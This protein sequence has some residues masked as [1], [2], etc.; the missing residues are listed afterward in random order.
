MALR[1]EP[2]GAIPEETARIA[3]AAFPKGHRYL[4]LRDELG[5]IYDDA[6]FAPLFPA[7][8][9]PAEA[10][11]RRALVTVLQFAEGLTDRQAADAVR[12]RL[13][14]K[15]LL[16]LELT[17]TGFD[18]SILGDFRARLVDGGAEHQLL[19]ALL[20]RGKAGGLIKT[21]GKQ[22]TDSTHVL[23]AVRALNRVECV[24]ETLRHTLNILAV[25][26]PEWLRAQVTADWYE[27]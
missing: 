14:W 26:A 11:W 17:D 12:D 24:G 8:G 3:Q 16:G 15:Y 27:R 23:A 10:P 2:S 9:R 22:R 20:E 6:R 18:D 1:P 4:R 5:T 7:Q 21:R 13:A 19:D 25:V